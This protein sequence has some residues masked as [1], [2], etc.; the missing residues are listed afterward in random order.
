MRLYGE[1]HAAQFHAGIVQ[2]CVQFFMTYGMNI[3]STRRID[4]KEESLSVTGTVVIA[5]VLRAD[6]DR[7][8]FRELAIDVYFVEFSSVI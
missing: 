2:A 8:V 6:V 3:C 1:S 5:S 4:Q 7:R